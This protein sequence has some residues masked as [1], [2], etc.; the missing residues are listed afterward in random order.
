MIIL[1]FLLV[2]NRLLKREDCY[3]TTFV[4]ISVAGISEGSSVKFQG[5]NIGT[6]RSITVD[7][8]DT[9][10]VDVHFCLKPGT[11]IKEGTTAQLEG[12]GITGMKFLEL[13]GGGKGKDIPVGGNIPS[14]RSAWDD[15]SGKA[16]VIATKLEEILNKVNI[17]L[18][19]VEPGTFGKLVTDVTGTV[20]SI[21]AILKK[22][23]KGVSDAVA[24]LNGIM[25][26]LHDDLKIYGEVGKNVKRLTCEDSDLFRSLNNV[27]T[28][29]SDF[30]TA[31]KSA[32]MDKNIKKLFEAIDRLNIAIASINTILLK[33]Q[34]NIDSSLKDL[35]DSL[36]N[37]SEFSRIIMENPSTLIQGNKGESR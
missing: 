28:I 25:A 21:N 9:S 10:R 20:E 24:Q 23:R 26:E 17:A 30:R 14:K 5:M 29:S 16:S 4:N 33:N 27:A 32:N 36:Y 1:I 11:P 19:E 18:G 8:D 13:K 34:G 31:Y 37:L 22:N 6:V 12:I 35:S 3:T 2:G 7:R 15:I